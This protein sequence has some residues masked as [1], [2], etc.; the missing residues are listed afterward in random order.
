MKLKQL[1]CIIFNVEH[2]FC[3]FIKSPN[4]YG[5]MIDCGR[6]AH[7]S[8][9]KWIRKNYN[10]NCQNITYFE[11]RRIAELIITHLHVDHFSDVGSFYSKRGDK[12]KI[13]C[14][15]K[16]I[17]KFIDQKINEENLEQRKELLKLFKKFQEDYSE[18]LTTNVDWGFDLDIGQISYNDAKRI[19]SDR[20]EIINNR[21]YIIGIG[22]ANKKIIF[23]GDILEKGWEEAF[24]SEA[25]KKILEDT[26]FFITS[27]HGLKS[28]FHPDI[29]KYTGKPDIYIVSAKRGSETFYDFYS[30]LENS[31]GHLVNGDEVISRVISTKNQSKSIKIVI[32]KNGITSI[33]TMTTED[34][35][36]QGQEKIVYRRTKKAISDLVFNYHNK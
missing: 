2:G 6:G 17:L 27:H 13:L 1:E 32:K 25:I 21:S 31:N 23:P 4:N 3:A 18:K 35:L 30:K 14:R 11:G 22:Y 26:N 24:K 19:S 20:D 8:P 36:N 10:F 9:I 5:L 28:G 29:L 12:P 34:N 7:F 33:E 16:K 15:D